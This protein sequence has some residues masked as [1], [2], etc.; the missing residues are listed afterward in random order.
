MHVAMLVP[1]ALA[2]LNVIGAFAQDSTGQTI[3]Q[4]AIADSIDLHSIPNTNLDAVLEAISSTYVHDNDAAKRYRPGRAPIVVPRGSNDII[5]VHAH[6]VPDWY[7]TIAPIT[8][9]NPT[10]SWNISSHLAFMAS[11]GISHSILTISTPG[12]NVYLNNRA[13]TVALARLLNE[14]VAAYARSRPDKFTFYAIVPLPYVDAAIAE[15]H[16]ALN[17]LN[18]SGIALYSNFHGRY[19]GDPSFSPF[20]KALNALGGQ[21]IV[22][23]HPT[24]PYLHL[25]G[26]FIEANPTTLPTGNIEFYFETARTISSLATSQT[27]LN[28]TALNYIFPHVG[29][30]WPSIADRLLKTYPPI[31]NAT[32]HALQTRVYWDSAGPTYSHQ[33]GGLL[34]Y[35][36]PVR[37]LLFG[38]D[39]P[40]APIFTYAGSLEAVKTS[41]FVDDEGREGLFRGNAVRLFGE[42][43]GG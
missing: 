33:V 35:D 1:A 30:A 22:Y 42:K 28:F 24:T 14:Q 18:A 9:G 3:L 4:N 5:D 12:A 10:P 7:R 6:C 21:Q 20:F 34:A 16:Y 31:Y 26:S 43:L 27:L 2:Y 17:T 23:V 38:T 25:N 29:G 37:Q 11:Q 39:Y 36:V 19:L 13:A 32:M 8:G 40:Y 41:R 15:A